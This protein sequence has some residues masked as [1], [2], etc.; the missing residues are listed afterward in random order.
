MSL[1]LKVHFTTYSTRCLLRYF[2]VDI[3]SKEL[4]DRRV[5]LFSYI[6]EVMAEE[7]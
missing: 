2:H 7:F 3:G 1:Y 6:A 5:C 4:V